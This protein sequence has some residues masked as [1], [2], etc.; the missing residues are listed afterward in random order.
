M[1]LRTHTFILAASAVAHHAAGVQ[2]TATDRPSPP[3]DDGVI[4]IK[5]LFRVFKYQNR[6]GT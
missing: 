5:F 1:F 3:V 4:R 2:R 6:C